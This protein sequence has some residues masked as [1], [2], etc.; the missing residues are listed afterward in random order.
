MNRLSFA[1]RV[2]FSTMVFLMTISTVNSQTQT[3]QQTQ[4]GK[5]GTFI[6]EGGNWKSCLKLTRDGRS[7]TWNLVQ[8]NGFFMVGDKIAYVD[9]N[10]CDNAYLTLQKFGDKNNTV[11]GKKNGVLQQPVVEFPPPPIDSEPTTFLQTLKTLISSVME[12]NNTVTKGDGQECALYDTQYLVVG[13]REKIYVWIGGEG[14][15][16]SKANF[17]STADFN[18]TVKMLKLKDCQEGSKPIPSDSSQQSLLEKTEKSADSKW[19][20]LKKP[21]MQNGQCY[22]LSFPRNNKPSTV[23]IKVVDSI[24]G[25]G[26]A[27]M[28]SLEL[29]AYQT[30]GIL[31]DDSQ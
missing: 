4:G 14:C 21:H 15:P 9:Q 7:L 10:G 5:A 11:V 8:V 1:R 17:N 20:V 22:Q 19:L 25:I 2:Y 27:S 30:I 24:D 13:D 29:E 28:A 31:L 3:L 12:P 26:T 6:A 23:K 18:G 16:D